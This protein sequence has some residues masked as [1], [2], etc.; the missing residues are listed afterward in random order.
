[1]GLYR[2][3]DL[4][5]VPGLLSLSRLPLAAVFPLTLGHPAAALAVL[6]AAGVS[7]VLDGWYARRFSQVTPT[8]TAL[9]PAT[10]KIFVLTVAVSL[11]AWGYLSPI[12]VVIIST[13]ELA[14]LPLVVWIAVSHHARQRRS[15]Q[16]TANLLGK[17]ATC[18]QF[19][20]VTAAV[21]RVPH[22]SWLVAVAGLAGALAGVGYWAR[23]LRD[24]HLRRAAA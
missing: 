21:F 16:P 2:A 10:D 9:D 6:I 19:A 3:R 22:L 11:V 23:A 1:M 13:R 4:W 24:G 12:E 5:R 20:V 14:E 15:D 17:A 18:L 7:D 8:G